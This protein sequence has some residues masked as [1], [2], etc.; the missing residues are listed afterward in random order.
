MRAPRGPGIR[1]LRTASCFVP[2]P[3]PLHVHTGG[4]RVRVDDS[5]EGVAVVLLLAGSCGVAEAVWQ[6]LPI[7]LTARARGRPCSE[8]WRSAAWKKLDGTTHT[9]LGS[10]AW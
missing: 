6:T 9:A 1:P 4:G 10:R 7:V 3:T 8:S 5:A 2:W